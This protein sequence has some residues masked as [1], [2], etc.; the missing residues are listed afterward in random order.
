[1]IPQL[2]ETN[3][4]LFAAANYNNPQ[5]YDTLEF[6]DDMKR[7][8]YIKRLFNRY[9]E[10]EDLKE[11]LI[12]NHIVIL[13]NV[14]NHDAVTRM[15]FFKLRGHYHYLKPFLELVNYLPETVSGIGLDNKTINTNEIVS[16]AGIK[17]ILSQI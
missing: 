11:R 16:D 4:M 6:Y 5:C 12:I 13:Y 17:K 15:L 7:F 3:F 10:T 1:M 9:E 14:F 2:D 8:K